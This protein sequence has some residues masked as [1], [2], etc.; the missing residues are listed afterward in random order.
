[1][2]AALTLEDVKK[3]IDELYGTNQY[4]IISGKVESQSSRIRVQHIPC[5]NI[6]DVLVKGFI[7][8]EKKGRCKL[9]NPVINTTR[10]TYTEETVRE[11]FVTV[12]GGE[13]TY[14]D[15]Y[16]NAHSKMHVR[17]EKCG[18][19][20]HVSSHMFFGSKQSRCPLCA[21]AKRGA[22]LLKNNHLQAILD[23][24]DDGDEYEW[25]EEYKGSNKD[26]LRIRHKRCGN[27]FMIRPNDF[28]Q[29]YRCKSC[30][31]S[32]YE[33]IVDRE[34]RARK[35][36]FLREFTFDDCRGKK[37]P[38]PFDFAI[39]LREDCK[40]LIEVDGELHGLEKMRVT[41]AIKEKFAYERDD[42]VLRRI[43]S[44]GDIIQQLDKIIA[45]FK[46]LM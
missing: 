1:M 42:L 17:H 8:P 45:E 33:L 34:L 35:I 24:A 2:A 9:C 7:S 14:V 44:S 16:I 40:L 38:L 22:H 41:D 36:S 20:F 43:D 32:Q 15:G 31:K 5:G 46:D 6:I 26:K 25:L 28:Q 29:G 37:L 10:N 18:N 21:N 11:R 19:V 3:R 39:L 12:T 23:E 27:E 30:N 13:Y 4:K